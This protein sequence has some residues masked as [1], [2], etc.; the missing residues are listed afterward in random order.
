ML[1]QATVDIPGFKSSQDLLADCLALTCN[2]MLG[3]A[4]CLSE[5]DDIKNPP[6]RPSAIPRPWLCLV[7]GSNASRRDTK[8]TVYTGNRDRDI[9]PL[10]FPGVDSNLSAV[11][12]VMDIPPQ[13]SRRKSG[14]GGNFSCRTK[15]RTRTSSG[16]AYAGNKKEWDMK[17]R[18]CPGL[19]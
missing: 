8:T 9:P 10:Y 14:G 17:G 2:L 6:N 1:P 5:R 3:Y 13:L 12:V 11:L 7:L 4:H 15:T 16:L 19:I 18:E